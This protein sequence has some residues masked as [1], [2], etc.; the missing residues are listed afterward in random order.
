MKNKLVA[1]ALISV[2][3]FGLHVETNAQSEAGVLFLLISPGVRADGMGE[4]FVAVADDASAIYWN[5]GGLAFQVEQWREGI[6]K[7]R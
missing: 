1:S 2:L 5:S 7:L 6:P 3:L 4:A